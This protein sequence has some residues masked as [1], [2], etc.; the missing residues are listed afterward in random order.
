MLPSSILIPL[1]GLI[2]LGAADYS[3]GG[4]VLQDDYSVDKFFSMFDFFTVSL[5]CRNLELSFCHRALHLDVKGV[6][7]T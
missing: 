5:D 7:R 2:P 3:A 6:Q 4:Y 1:A